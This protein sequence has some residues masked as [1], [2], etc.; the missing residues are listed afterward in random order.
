M[1]SG[2]L[3]AEGGLVTEGPDLRLATTDGTE[4]RGFRGS[5]DALALPSTPEEVAAVVAWCY[6]HDVP[7][8]PRGGG[9]GLAGGAVPDGGVVVSLER[10]DRVRRIDPERWRMNAEAGVRTS[11]IHRVSRENGLLFPP[12]PGAA[13]QSTLGGNIATNAG[14]P[15][16]FKYGVTG[17]WVTGLEV[18]L[19]PGE[20]VEVG[21]PI[22][23]DVSGY[24]LLHLLI[25]SEGTLGIVTSAWLRLIPAPETRAVVYAFYNS[26]TAGCEAVAAVTANGI[27]ASVMEYLEGRALAA[28]IGSFPFEAPA[29]PAFAV[30]CE[31]D[32]S[33]TEVERVSAE[34][35]EVL[36]TRA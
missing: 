22:R 30:I 27:E 12:D 24:D 21:G 33:E 28:S 9:T 23:K 36:A 35:A 10:L 8:I 6:E 31:V 5:C 26:V 15:H 32:G 7:V 25:G 29:D 1:S 19:P 18:V 13:E 17:S 2:A 20:L 3:L 34:L 11:R 16:A 14:G 4:A